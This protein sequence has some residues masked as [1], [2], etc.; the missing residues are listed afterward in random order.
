MRR[1]IVMLALVLGTL[2]ACDTGGGNQA[3]PPASPS[4]SASEHEPSHNPSDGET[5][6][7]HD[8]Y[9]EAAGKFNLPQ[10]TIEKAVMDVRV[11]MVP[12]SSGGF[13]DAAVLR[14]F[15]ERLGVP[16]DRAKEVMAFLVEE[17]NEYDEEA[18]QR[19]PGY[20]AEWVAYV[21]KEL[22]ITPTRAAWL[23]NLLQNRPVYVEPG[24][25]W[26]AVFAAIARNV[27][28]TPERLAQVVDAL[29]SR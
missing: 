28:V 23:H 22:K 27:G 26:D 12:M 2:A 8:P 10:R 11:A 14:L 15:T 9:K 7:H 3:A 13:L 29:K 21:S 18:E 4:P 20:R 1:I 16:A 6:G 17:W 19:T 25:E 24:Q 5:P